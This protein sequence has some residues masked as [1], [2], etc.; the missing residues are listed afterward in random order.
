MRSSYVNRV[1]ACASGD[2]RAATVVASSVAEA[3][4]VTESSPVPVETSESA[5]AV[6]SSVAVAVMATESSPVPVETSEC[7]CNSNFFC[8]VL[9]LSS[10]SPV[11][12]SEPAAI[13]PDDALAAIEMLSSPVS[14]VESTA[15][16]AIPV[17]ISH[18]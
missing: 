9:Q 11:K 2:F 18:E 8:T 5:T 12:I 4:M 3:V 6:A 15:P 17:L 14:I 13:A 10:P 16:L 1:I 7:D